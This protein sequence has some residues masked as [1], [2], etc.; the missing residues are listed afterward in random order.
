MPKTPG[1]APTALSV[2]HGRP[3]RQLSRG[4]LGVVRGVGD[5]DDGE[6]LNREAVIAQRFHCTCRI[7]VAGEAVH[8][9][10]RGEHGWGLHVPTSFVSV[11]MRDRLS[12]GTQAV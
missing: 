1:E 4:L 8:E 11:P 7:A 2:A 6:L 10:A 5:D 9:M 3:G 12:V